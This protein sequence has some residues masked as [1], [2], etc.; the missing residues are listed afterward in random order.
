VTEA[1]G[2][3]PEPV[4]VVQQGAI[5]RTTS[6]KPRRPVLREA[7]LGGALPPRRVLAALS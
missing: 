6:G 4:L 1:L 2:T 7:V 5:P 3:R